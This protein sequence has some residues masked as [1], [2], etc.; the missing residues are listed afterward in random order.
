MYDVRCT[1]YDGAR[2]ESDCV[3]LIDVAKVRSTK[4]EVRICTVYDSAKCYAGSFTG[5]AV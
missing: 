3:N 4:Y 1:M 2:M 5:R